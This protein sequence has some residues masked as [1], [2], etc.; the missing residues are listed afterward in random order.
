M[1]NRTHILPQ[2]KQCIYS[3]HM[4]NLT[5]CVYSFVATVTS[6]QQCWIS[7]GTQH[8]YFELPFDGKTP[9]QARSACP[10]GSHLATVVSQEED[11]FI[12]SIVTRER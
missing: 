3:C 4:N 8:C 6:A 7:N 9:L 10:V 5:M 11:D 12:Q 1:N 2:F